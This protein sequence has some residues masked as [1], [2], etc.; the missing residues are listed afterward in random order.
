MDAIHHAPRS[1]GAITLSVWRALFL[2]EALT[3]IVA[4][5][6]AWFWLLA[7]PVLHMSYIVVLYTII[8]VKT[9]GGID[10]GVWIAVGLLAYFTFQRTSSQVA[11]AIDANQAL[12]AYRQVKPMDALLVRAAL[13][14]FLMMISSAVVAF[15]ASLWG[16]PVIPDDPL[17]VMLAFFGMW[18][19]GLGF[20]MLTSIAI[21][22][23][24]EF[25]N[26]LKLI[27]RPLYFISGVL[28]PIAAIP[29]PYRDYM[30]WNPLVHGLEAARLGF[31]LN[32]HAVDGLSLFYLYGCALT[33][34]FLG[35][36]LHSHF[37]KRL[38]IR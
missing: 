8:R 28:H 11:N 24:P 2:R 21:E 17:V 12:F 26:V 36:A 1:S 37:A 25:G 18:S 32:Y 10:T 31:S 4:R 34:V 16:Y 35:L 13:E 19:F 29:Q 22:F 5:R 14:G 7:E 15:F 3:R 20:G 9:I 30:M 23:L 38:V 27:T 33:A 6:G